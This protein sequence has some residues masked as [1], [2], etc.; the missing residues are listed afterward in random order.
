MPIER[1][2]CRCEY[3]DIALAASLVI[4]K[5]PLRDFHPMLAPDSRWVIQE[6]SMGF[7]IASPQVRQETIDR[8]KVYRK[9]GK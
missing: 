7:P 2:E 6:D 8:W 9:E 3:R 1:V 5:V 4:A